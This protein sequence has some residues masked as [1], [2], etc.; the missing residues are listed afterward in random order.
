MTAFEERPHSPY[1]GSADSTPLFLIL[2]DEYERWT[3]D[4]ALARELE[5]EA[6]AAL[7]WIDR[8]GDR[9]GDG[10]IEYERRNTETGLENQCWKDSWDSI[11]FADGTLAAAAARHLRAPGLR[12]RRQASGPRGWR[13]RS[14]TTPRGPTQLEREAA[15]LKRRFNNDFWIAERSFFALALDGEKRKVDSLTS[16]IGHLLWSGIVDDDKAD[17]LRRASDERRAVLRL[18]HPHDGDQPRA[19]TTRS[20]TTSA[21][22]GRTTTRS[23]P[24]GCAATATAT[25]R[26]ASA[27]AMLE[28]AEL[29]HHRLPEAFAG[30]PREATTALPGRVPDRVQPAGVGD[31]NAAAL[32]RTLLGLDSDGRH[33]IVDPAPEAAR[34]D[35]AARH[36]G[37]LGADGCVRA[38][39]RG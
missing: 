11:A 17:A 10:Y 12:L 3:G 31:R 16:N 29:F 25:R 27:A 20:A 38:G 34:S 36:P 22:S 19:R 9:D 23:S 7:A 8:Y 15:E 2:L 4:R 1:Y 5:R 24:G 14:G 32:L 28:A 39:A 26:R 13:A 37:L 21:P 30:Y 35:R 33:L 6:R 18:G